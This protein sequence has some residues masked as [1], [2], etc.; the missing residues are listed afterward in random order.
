[1]KLLCTKHFE[2]GELK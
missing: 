1:M 2:T